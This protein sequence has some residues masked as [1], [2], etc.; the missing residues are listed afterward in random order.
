MSSQDFPRQRALILL[1]TAALLIWGLLGVLDVSN[2]TFTGFLTDGNNNITQVLENSPAEAAGF[3]RGDR[4]RT[5][6][7]IPVEDTRAITARIRPSVGEERTFQIERDDQIVD[8]EL[9]YAALPIDQRLTAFG[10]ILIGLSFLVFGVWAYLSEPNAKTGLL[11][12]LGFAFAPTLLVGPYVESPLWRNVVVTIVLVIE[13]FAFVFLAHFLIT[14]PKSISEFLRKKQIT[15]LYGPAVLMS[16]IVI[17]ASVVRP[18][19]TSLFNIVFRT[20]FG[21]FLVGYFGLALIAMLR[22]YFKTPSGER[23]RKGMNLLLLGTAVGLGPITLVILIGLIAPQIVIPGGQY[24][25][26]TLIILPA[27]YAL[28]GVREARQK[29]SST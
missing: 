10:A 11:A 21:V 3:V 16:L 14:F 28:A 25:Y 26:L 7:G 24:S 29:D 5:N 4:I 22:G 12:L 8:L 13:L 1:V 20:L 2:R 9:T 18:E 6:G 19:G 15:V 17:W 23:T 27:T